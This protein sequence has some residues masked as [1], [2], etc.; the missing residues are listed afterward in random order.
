M[1]EQELYDVQLDH[2]DVVEIGNDIVNTSIAHSEGV[3]A[4]PVLDRGE[5][6]LSDDL[7]GALG[8]Y[9]PGTGKTRI[10]RR[11]AKGLLGLGIYV[12]EAYHKVLDRVFG[13]DRRL[14]HH[15]R[16]IANVNPEVAEA[17]WEVGKEMNEGITDSLRMDRIN[18][19]LVSAYE[20]NGSV[21]AAR[22]I[23]RK[24][25]SIRNIVDNMMS[26]IR[27]YAQIRSSQMVY[28]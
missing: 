4:K 15:A 10:L 8:T 24:Y 25:G 16:E 12:H 21:A 13:Y 17:V 2:K 6:E 5:V 14:A 28:A 1:S 19:G 3:D 11:Y 22:Q 7:D 27:D 18:A 26:A 23:R 20:R 9:N